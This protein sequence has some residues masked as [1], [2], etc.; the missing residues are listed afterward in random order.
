LAVRKDDKPIRSQRHTRYSTDEHPFER[1]MDF[2]KYNSLEGDNCDKKPGKRWQA[3]FVRS[4]RRAV[5]AKGACHLF[6]KAGRNARRAAGDKRCPSPFPRAFFH[7]NRSLVGELWI[8]VQSEHDYSPTSQPALSVRVCWRPPFGLRA[9]AG[10]GVPTR[11]SLG[12]L[13]TRH[14]RGSA[15]PA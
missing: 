11:F 7:G 3:P 12:R 1:R 2:L 6:P 15:T 10:N 9:A 14:G 13:R 4:T 8:M 5:P